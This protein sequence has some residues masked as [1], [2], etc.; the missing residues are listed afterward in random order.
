[1]V[2]GT[3]TINT[4]PGTVTINQ[5]TTTASINWQDFSIATGELTRFQVPTSASATLNRVTGGN[6]S[7]I[8]GTLQSNGQVYLLNPNGI[9]SKAL[10]VS[11]QS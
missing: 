9:P 10:I 2:S 4:I 1:M 5:A 6:A 8:Y 11:I 3:A 7:A